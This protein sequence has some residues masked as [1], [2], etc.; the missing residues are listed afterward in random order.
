MN[1]INIKNIKVDKKMLFRYWLVF[2]KPYHNLRQKEIEALSLFLYYRHKLSE[3][4]VNQELVDK[5]LFSQDI[6]NNI[7]TELK[8]K[9]TY[10]FNNMLTSLRKKGVLSKDNKI[11]EVLIPNFEK[12][13]DNFKLVFNFEINDTK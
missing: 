12:S 10:M 2:L 9:N 7:M 1:N 11:K 4:V 5:L 13:S 3:E 8:I 6:R